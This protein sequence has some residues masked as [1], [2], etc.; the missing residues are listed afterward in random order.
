MDL[1]ARRREF[2]ALE[3]SVH[4]HR[5]AYLDSAATT[6]VPRA[7]IDAMTASLTTM[8]NAGRGVHARSQAANDAVDK[9]REVVASAL[10]GAAAEV[11]FTTGTTASVNL[12]ADTWG[13]AHVQHGDV[14]IASEAEHHSNDLPW[15][16]LCQERSAT[17]VEA[18]VDDAGHFDLA[19]FEAQVANYGE[20]TKLV[21][22]GHVSNV[23]GTIAPVAEIA[24]IARSVGARVLV[25]GAQAIAHLDVDVHALGCDFYAFSGHKL[26]G[27]MGAGVLW[28]R[29]DVLDSMAPYHVGSNMAHG[30]EFDRAAVRTRRA[31]LPGRHAGRR[32]RR[33]PGRG[34]A[35]PRTPRPVRRLVP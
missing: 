26:C 29:R 22:I 5:L 12:V 16:R 33:G 27:P 19:A 7:V 24:R 9:A 15:R 11:V 10:H 23:L 35:V 14:V 17:F 20:R 8:G 13:K 30:V 3:H 2:P 1:A 21:A 6:L 4:G 25:D 31:A 28:A 18:R 34:A 32:R